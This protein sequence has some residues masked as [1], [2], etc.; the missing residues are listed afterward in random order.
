MRHHNKLKKFGR[1]SKQRGALMRSLARALIEKE[2][3]ETTHAK[4]RALRTF[5]EKL[6]TYGKENSLARRRLVIARLGGSTKEAN[7]LFITLAPRYEK[8]HGG[9]TRITKMNPKYSDGRKSSVIEFV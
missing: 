6:V 5:I 8:R 3:I 2:K 4:A 1:I 9:Y 7:K